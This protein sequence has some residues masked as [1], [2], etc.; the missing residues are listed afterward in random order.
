MSGTT[1]PG[2]LALDESAE[3]NGREDRGR[4]I[5]AYLIGF[6]IALLL[7]A[8]SFA[9]VMTDLVWGPAVPAAIVTL[10]VAQM[11]VHLVF[12]LHLDRSSESRWNVN[13]AAFTV[14]VIGIIVIGTLWVM[15]NMNVHMMH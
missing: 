7:T 4:G 9:V 12:F 5:A 11:G 15:H 8:A 3:R 2:A 10:A 6:G 1:E 14:V 13:A